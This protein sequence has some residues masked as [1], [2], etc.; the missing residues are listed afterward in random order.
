MFSIAGNMKFLSHRE[1][2]NHEVPYYSCILQCL[3]SD[4]AGEAESVIQSRADHITWESRWSEV[5][6]EAGCQQ[7]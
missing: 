2:Q 4:T 5:T 6:E 3:L 7:M 1:N